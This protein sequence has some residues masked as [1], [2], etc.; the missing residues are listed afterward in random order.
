MNGNADKITV[1]I[2]PAPAERVVKVK[3]LFL[4]AANAGKSTL[5]RN[6]RLIHDCTFSEEEIQATIDG[7]RV[8]TMEALANF[9]KA[10]GVSDNA[11]KELRQMI[12]SFIASVEGWS[13]MDNPDV[14]TK[15]IHQALKISRDPNVQ[16][17]LSSENLAKIL[18]ENCSLLANIESTFRK[19]YYPTYDD[20]LTIRKPTRVSFFTK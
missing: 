5:I 20:I 14:N 13:Y 2:T 1:E 7:M 12:Y 4:G 15:L 3:V 17:C 16:E 6:I 8:M 11:S 18:N 19:D 9:I 10:T